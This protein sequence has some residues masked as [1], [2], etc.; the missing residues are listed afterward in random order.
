VPY[1]LGE[2]HPAGKRLADVQKCIRTGD[3]EEV[4]DDTHV[5]FIE[6]LGNWSLGDY[7]KEDAIKWS[8]EFLTNPN[9]GLG[10]P[11]ERL[12]FSVFAG[13]NDAPRDEQSAAIWKSLGVKEGRIAYLPKEDN[14][15]IAGATGLCGPEL[16]RPRILARPKTTNAGWKF[17]IMCSCSTNKK[18]TAN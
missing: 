12:G 4:G 8:F 1:L 13:D 10:L 18:P 15:W 7:F 5:T 11:V 6:M 14:W 3:I 9:T 2:K 16:R 17:G